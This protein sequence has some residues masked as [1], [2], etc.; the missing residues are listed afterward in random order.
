MRKKYRYFDPEKAREWERRDATRKAVAAGVM[1]SPLTS[2]AK[3]I[4]KMK[5]KENKLEKG[6]SEIHREFGSMK[7]CILE[8]LPKTARAECLECILLALKKTEENVINKLVHI[9]I[10]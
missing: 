10:S 4:G 7:E 6:I 3:V 9:S 8:A 1:E 2:L 5:K